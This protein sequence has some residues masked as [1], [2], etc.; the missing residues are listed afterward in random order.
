MAKAYQALT[1]EE[2]REN[3]EKY[4]NPD[5]PK[6]TTFG[7]ALPKWIVSENYGNWVLALYGLVFIVL[8]PVIVGIWWYNSMK[9]SVDKVLNE[10]SQ[11]FAHFIHKTPAMEVDRKYYKSLLNLYFIFFIL[12][13]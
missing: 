9:Y 10:T 2:S 12:F 13:F 11:I 3:W 8:L 5:G 1:N 4:G 6:A 7:I